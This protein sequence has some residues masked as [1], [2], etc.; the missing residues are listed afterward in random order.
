MHRF[1]MAGSSPAITKGRRSGRAKPGHD[2]GGGKGGRTKPNM[3]SGR[4]TGSA[5]VRKAPLHPPLRFGAVP[6]DHFRLL[7]VEPGEIGLGFAV[8][9]QEFVELGME[10]LGVTVL[11]TLDDQG[12]DE[13][14]ED[15]T[16]VPAKVV[17]IEDDPEDAIEDDDHKSGRMRGPHAK[18][19]EPEAD[20]M[21]HDPGNVAAEPAFQHGSV[22]PAP[23]RPGRGRGNCAALLMLGVSRTRASKD[24][25]CA[26][27]R[28]RAGSRQVREGDAGAALAASAQL[29]RPATRASAAIIPANDDNGDPAPSQAHIIGIFSRLSSRACHGPRPRSALAR[30]NEKARAPRSAGSTIASG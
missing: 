10:G 5:R 18:S 20:G 8:G 17:P 22:T 25:V 1:W 9:A 21:G 29:R 16:L 12:H 13:R 26:T 28:R 15:S 3:T 14:R 23:S 27:E 24:E 7:V 2:K 4:R 6:L 11:G 19:R 30:K